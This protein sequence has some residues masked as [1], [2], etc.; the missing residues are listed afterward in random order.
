MYLYT[1]GHINK[2]TAIGAINRKSTMNSF[3]QKCHPEQCVRDV[4]ES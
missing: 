1:Y 3:P 4:G 2:E